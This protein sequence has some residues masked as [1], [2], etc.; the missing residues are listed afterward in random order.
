MGFTKYAAEFKKPL[1]NTI[2]NKA[3]YIKNL[4]TSTTQ[5]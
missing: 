1:E 4:D 2:F 3:T 5:I